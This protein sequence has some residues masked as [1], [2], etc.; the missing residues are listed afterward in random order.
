[1]KSSYSFENQPSKPCRVVFLFD[2][3]RPWRDPAFLG[4]NKNAAW[5]G[6]MDQTWDLNPLIMGFYT[7]EV[8]LIAIEILQ[9][10]PKG[11]GYI[12]QTTHF[13]SAGKNTE[14][15]A[16]VGRLWFV[17]LPRWFWWTIHTKWLGTYRY[18]NIGCWMFYGHVTV[19]ERFL[20]M[21]FPRGK[22]QKKR[23][24]T[25]IDLLRVG[26]SYPPTTYQSC[27]ACLVSTFSIK[28]RFGIPR[29]MRFVFFRRG[30]GRILKRG[31]PRK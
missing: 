5:N 13:L 20:L 14:Q 19:P 10:A 25:K 22:F 6:C 30:G 15:L 26:W 18:K 17:T 16:G 9:K 2:F 4:G 29:T 11:K 28:K 27:C 7:P 12:S 31:E 8:Q 1:M 3:L 21:G 23:Q 24:E